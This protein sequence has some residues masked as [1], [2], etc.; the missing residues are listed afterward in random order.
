M[1][2]RVEGDGAVDVEALEEGM[3]RA[4]E[5]ARAS[6]DAMRVRADAMR[7]T[8]PLRAGTMYLRGGDGPGSA[9]FVRGRLNGTLSGDGGTLA[10]PGLRL[11]RVNADL[12]SYFGAGSEGG[13]LVTSSEGRW[14][15]LHEGDVVV[16]VNGTPVR[17]GRETRISIDTR[18][19]NEFEVLRKGKR[20]KVTVEGDDR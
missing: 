19:R 12:A 3:Q 6:A 13:L 18:D 2:I 15:A 20:E 7:A 5:T 14:S 8:L 1:R 17:D 4:R 10:L 16:A 9:S 11:S